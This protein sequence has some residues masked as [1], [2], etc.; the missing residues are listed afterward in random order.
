M[1]V[2]SPS[3]LNRYAASEQNLHGWFLVRFALSLIR[4][5]HRAAYNDCLSHTAGTSTTRRVS[6]TRGHSFLWASQWILKR[7]RVR[8]Y[9]AGGLQKTETRGYPEEGGRARRQER[10][11]VRVGEN[12]SCVIEKAPW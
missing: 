10:G 7:L 11:S 12:I 4:T 3:V 9:G 5:G 8:K 6:V 1:P 2:V